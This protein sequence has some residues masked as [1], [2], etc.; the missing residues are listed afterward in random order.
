MRHSTSKL[1]QVLVTGSRHHAIFRRWQ[2]LRLYVF[3]QLRFAV[4]RH[5]RVDSVDVARRTTPDHRARRIVAAVDQHGADESLRA[6]RRESIR[7]GGRRSCVRPRPG[8]GSRRGRFHAR[9]FASDGLLYEARPHQRQRVFVARRETTATAIPRSRS[10]VPRRRDIRVVRCWHRRR[11][12]ASARASAGL[13]LRRNS[14]AVV[15]GVR[16]NPSVSASVGSSRRYVRDH[17]KSKRLLN[18]TTIEML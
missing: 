9:C 12:G 1:R 15:R 7:D 5:L 11:C 8:A 6:C 4:A 13:R 2:S 16:A 3:L 14:Q 17:W 18:A 10:R